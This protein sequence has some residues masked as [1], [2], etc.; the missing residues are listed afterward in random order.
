MPELKEKLIKYLSNNI[1][2]Y[3]C[4][5]SCPDEVALNEDLRT[6]E[7]CNKCFTEQIITLVK[8]A[9]YVKLAD[10]DYRYLPIKETYCYDNGWR[11]VKSK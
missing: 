11:K 6:A 7:Y 5:V 3:D 1:A 9:N 8:E 4:Q 10:M 2:L